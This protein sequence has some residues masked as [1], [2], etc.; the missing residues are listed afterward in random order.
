ME[1]TAY[2][3]GSGFGIPCHFEKG[4]DLVFD[5]WDF[6]FYLNYIVYL[7]HIWTGEME[8]NIFLVDDLVLISSCVLE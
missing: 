5:S 1:T 4:Y 6:L 7:K 3:V 2:Y 8:D